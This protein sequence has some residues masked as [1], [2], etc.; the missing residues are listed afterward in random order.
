M[1]KK[2]FISMPMNGKTDKRIREDLEKAKRKVVDGY[3]DVEFVDS[4]FKDGD[5]EDP[6]KMLGESIKLLADADMVYFCDGWESARGCRIEHEVAT[7]YDRER[8]YE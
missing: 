3:G 7:V 4:Y 8:A 1:G 2:V 5:K 6:I